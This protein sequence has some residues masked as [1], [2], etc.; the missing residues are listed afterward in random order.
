MSS[1]KT[2]ANCCNEGKV[3]LPDLKECHE[4]LNSLLTN[5]HPQAVNFMKKIRNYNSALEF[6]SIGA[7]VKIPPGVGTY[8]CRIYGMV[9]HTTSSI[10]QNSLNP[11][12]ADLYFMGSAQVTDVRLHNQEI[13]D[14]SDG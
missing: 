7:N 8:C 4:F 11:G 2:F 3:I 6:A 10:G 12:Y 9:Y 14:A 1:D 13:Q 5:S